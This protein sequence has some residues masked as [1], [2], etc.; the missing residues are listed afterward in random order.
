MID[1]LIEE[2]TPYLADIQQYALGNKQIK[3]KGLHRIRINYGKLYLDGVKTI[4]S[5][6]EKRE[7]ADLV[8][9]LESLKNELKT[10]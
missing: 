3:D 5:L 10:L 9:E 2:L 4:S 7:I 8:Q 6:I 1:S